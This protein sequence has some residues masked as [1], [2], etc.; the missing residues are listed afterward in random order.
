MKVNHVGYVVKDIERYAATMPGLTLKK[1]LEDPLQH[2]RLALYSV[3][4]G[5]FIE[6]IQPHGPEAFTWGHLT[7]SGEGMH[8]V[9]YEGLNESDVASLMLQHRMLKVRGPIYAPLFDRQVIFGITRNHAIVEF[10]L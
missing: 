4:D 7:R 6:L 2:A 3:G 9:C 10:L 1:E 8:H 5:A